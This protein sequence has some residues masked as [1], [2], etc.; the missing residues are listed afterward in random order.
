MRRRWRAAHTIGACH[1]QE[2]TSSVNARLSGVV[3][4]CPDPWAL[5]TFYSQIT[6]WPIVNTDVDWCSIGPNEDA[7]PRLSL[8]AGAGLPTPALAGPGVID[9]ISPRL[10]GR[11]SRRGG[12]SRPGAWR[13]EIRRAA[14]SGSFPRL[15]RPRRPPVLPVHPLGGKELLGREL[16][17][18]DALLV[19]IAGQRLERL[20]VR[21]DADRRD[22]GAV[23]AA[24]P[25]EQ[26]GDLLLQA[27][28]PRP[29]APA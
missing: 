4:E 29:A 27:R 26:V 8:P 7:R 24:G 22:A 15:R 1:P 18:R 21:F 17:R 25:F 3:L 2:P 11:R 5:A 28:G 16:L 23:T 6:G 9:A 19:R 12:G 10:H 13:D 20:A 14:Q